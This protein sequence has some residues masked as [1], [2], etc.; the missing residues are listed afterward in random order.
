MAALTKP[1]FYTDVLWAS[2]TPAKQQEVSD[3]WLALDPATQ[4]QYAKNAQPLSPGQKAAVAGAKNGNPR[5]AATLPGGGF[6]SATNPVNAGKAMTTFPVSKLQSVNLPQSFSS[7]LPKTE[8][9]SIDWW[10]LIDKGLGIAQTIN[11][12]NLQKKST[13]LANQSFDYARQA[14]EDRAPL[15]VMAMDQLT[16]P[17]EPDVSGLDDVAGRGNPFATSAARRRAVPVRVGGA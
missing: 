1:P 13:K 10:N 11:A 8:D 5:T 6:P 7:F 4:S 12:A 15:R 17:K 9:G 3:W 2:L 14:Y 16:H